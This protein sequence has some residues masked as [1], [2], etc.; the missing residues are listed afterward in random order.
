M[1][2]I[3]NKDN[4]YGIGNKSRTGMT[5]S[6]ETNK[7]IG[8]FFWGKPKTAAQREK[9]SLARKKWWAERKKKEPGDEELYHVSN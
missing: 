4:Q 5:N 9:M 2:K 3:L 8:A 1:M 6:P 7:K